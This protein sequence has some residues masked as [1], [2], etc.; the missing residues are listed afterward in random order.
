[1]IASRRIGSR[2]ITR[3]WSL[4]RVANLSART[5]SSSAGGG[6]LATL[7]GTPSM[8]RLPAD[9]ITKSALRRSIKIPA[10]WLNGQLAKCG[11]RQCQIAKTKGHAMSGPLCYRMCLA[12]ILKFAPLAIDGSVAIGQIG[13]RRLA[14]LVLEPARVLA[15]VRGRGRVV[16][17]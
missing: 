4:T 10:P 14:D 2:A 6:G 16:S 15:R 17:C 5:A 7:G 9:P 1:M 8:T 11:L 3:S 12:K 13:A